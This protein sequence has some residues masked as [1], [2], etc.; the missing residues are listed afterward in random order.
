MFF[1]F[2]LKRSPGK[3]R[4]IE[5][6]EPLTNIFMM[7][8]AFETKFGPV[9]NYATIFYKTTGGESPFA[10][11][12]SVSFTSALLLGFFLSSDINYARSDPFYSFFLILTNV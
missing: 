6:S 7:R 9:Y 10:W 2:S 11:A 8:Y 3:E 12:S 4:S 5:R 1:T